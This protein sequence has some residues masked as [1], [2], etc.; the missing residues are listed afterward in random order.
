MRREL[1]K[2]ARR[3]GRGGEKGG[4]SAPR[5]NFC[6]GHRTLI[7]KKNTWNFL[8]FFFEPANFFM[9]AAPTFGDPDSAKWSNRFLDKRLFVMIVEVPD[10]ELSRY[11]N[12]GGECV[13]NS[14]REDA[15]GMS[16]SIRS[17][18]ETSE[19]STSL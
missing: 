18:P 9:N 2:S 11:H 8:R 5:P 10:P 17:S 3:G 19:D 4:A 7:L 1:T 14:I 16:R 15:N 13:Y 6:F 12:K